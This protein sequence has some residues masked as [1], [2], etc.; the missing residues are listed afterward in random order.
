MSCAVV[1]STGKVVTVNDALVAPAGTVTDA[2]TLAEPGKIAA[3][4]DRE[5]TG[6]R[7][8]V[9]GDGARRRACHLAHWSD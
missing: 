5:P 7:G 2:G 1:L 4:A 9:E 6:W 3:Q 8:A